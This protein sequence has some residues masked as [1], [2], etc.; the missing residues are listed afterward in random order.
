VHAD[1]TGP[2]KHEDGLSSYTCVITDAFTKIVHLT[3]N[4]TKTAHNM[5]KCL[6]QWCITYGVPKEVV[7]DRGLEFCNETIREV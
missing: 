4:P 1:L 3:T 5:A 2:K 6:M 7:T